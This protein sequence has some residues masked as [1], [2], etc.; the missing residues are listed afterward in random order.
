V[1]DQVA[2]INRATAAADQVARQ[3][4]AAAVWQATWIWRPGARHVSCKIQLRE[5]TVSR[6]A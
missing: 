1:I 3:I 5:G 6:A 4:A 2:A